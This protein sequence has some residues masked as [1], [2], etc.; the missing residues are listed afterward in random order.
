MFNYEW[1][2]FILCHLR[3]EPKHGFKSVEKQAHEPYL[4]AGSCSALWA[5]VINMNYF[6]DKELFITGCIFLG[7]FLKTFLTYL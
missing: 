4:K 7:Q 2:E 6:L 1:I 3:L 5:L